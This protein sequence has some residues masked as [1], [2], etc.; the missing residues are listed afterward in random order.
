MPAPGIASR[1]LVTLHAG[2]SHSSQYT[3]QP[4][5]RLRLRQ[6]QCTLVG[7]Q[8]YSE[9]NY[10]AIVSH[11]EGAHFHF[12][13]VYEDGSYKHETEESLFAARV[14]RALGSRSASELLLCTQLLIMGSPL[15]GGGGGMA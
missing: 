11:D 9:D 10:V 2:L 3:S 1:T 12:L 7:R 13:T 4:R 8:F 5:I 14:T 15:D 6:Q